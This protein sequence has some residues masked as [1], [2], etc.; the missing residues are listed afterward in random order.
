MKDSNNNEASASDRTYT[1]KP[2]STKR[3]SDIYERFLDRV[4]SMEFDSTEGNNEVIHSDS[5]SLEINLENLDK[6]KKLSSYE[7]LNEEELRFFMNHE[8]AIGSEEVVI[9][10][11]DPDFNDD[12]DGENEKN[13]KAEKVVSVDNYVLNKKDKDNNKAMVLSAGD[14]VG[15]VAEP[16]VEAITE[17]NKDQK[18]KSTSSGKLLVI[19]VICGLLLSAAIIVLL[20]KTGF[21]SA[22]TERSDSHS[23]KA[24]SVISLSRPIADAE[25]PAVIKTHE[26][27][28]LDPETLVSAV[29]QVNQD[30]VAVNPQEAP[31]EPQQTEGSNRSLGTEPAISIKDFREEAQNT[32]YRETKD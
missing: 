6:F 19:G 20:N 5:N 29:P 3:T 23:S 4:Q 17:D 1:H 12:F 18:S 21:L 15:L 26:T 11:I 2:S 22:S 7:P 14:D 24:I 28:A 31:A 25:Q 10:S 32:L 30:K 9:T 27:S 8:A 16:R 13:S